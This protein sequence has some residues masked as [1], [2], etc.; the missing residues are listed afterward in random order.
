MNNKLLYEVFKKKKIPILKLAK[1]C[2]LSYSTC[3]DIL[4]GKKKNP[5]ILSVYKIASYLNISIDTLMEVTS[6]E[7]DSIKD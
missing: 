2:D 6:D 3:H 5:S 4:T 1:D 7:K